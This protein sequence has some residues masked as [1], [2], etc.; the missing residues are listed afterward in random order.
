VPGFEANRTVVR[1]K[2]TKSR[3]S[4]GIAGLLLLVTISSLL[5]IALLRDL[6]AAESTLAHRAPYLADLTAMAVAA[7]GA[8]NDERVPPHG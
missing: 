3:L 2:S 7:K 5:G 6:N 4:R 8:A 1:P